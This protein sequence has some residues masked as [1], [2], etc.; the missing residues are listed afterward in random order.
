M[1]FIQNEVEYDGPGIY[2]LRGVNN[3]F[4]YVGKSNNVSRRIKQ[5]DYALRSQNGQS[6]H[7]RKKL[8]GGEIFYAEI[9]D[10]ISPDRSRYYIRDLEAFY[11][12]RYD[13]YGDNGLNQAPIDTHIKINGSLRN[14]YSALR[15]RVDWL[16]RMVGRYEERALL[17]TTKHTDYTE[18]LMGC[19]ERDIKDICGLIIRDLQP[20]VTIDE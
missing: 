15:G 18:K 2:L 9:L 14:G 12:D 13:A 11:I 3:D 6:D 7:I 8:S 17:N 4:V 16:Y 20:I 5:H 19:V 10:K 1:A